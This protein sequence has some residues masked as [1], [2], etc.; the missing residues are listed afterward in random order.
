MHRGDEGTH[1]A[2]ARSVQFDASTYTYAEPSICSGNSPNGSHSVL[3]LPNYL[4][5]KHALHPVRS[6]RDAPTHIDAVWV[7]GHCVAPVTERALHEYQ[8]FEARGRLAQL[9]LGQS[10]ARTTR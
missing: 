6:L 3:V 7:S 10:A 2:R 4:A 5:P 9:Q 8:L 1:L